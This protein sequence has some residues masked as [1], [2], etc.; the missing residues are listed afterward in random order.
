MD[1]AW[2]SRLGGS[3]IGRVNSRRRPG[4]V[5]LGVRPGFEA[6]K[7]QRNHGQQ[8]LQAFGT[9]LPWGDFTLAP[10]GRVLPARNAPAWVE[11]LAQM[12]AEPLSA[13]EH[14]LLAQ[15][16][17]NERRWDSAFARFWADGL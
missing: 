10:M 2:R 12:L 3:G 17:G 5:N 14:H 9:L 13:E 4:A 15:Q 16:A 6:D 8:N 1:Q 11:G 7:N